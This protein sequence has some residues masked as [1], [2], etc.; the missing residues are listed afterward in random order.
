MCIKIEKT[1]VTETDMVV[2]SIFVKADG[3]MV[4]PFARLPLTVGKQVAEESKSDY[5]GENQVG[6]HRFESVE[7]AEY[8]TRVATNRGWD[9]NVKIYKSIIPAGTKVCSGEIKENNFG[10]GIPALL[11]PVIIQTD[12][13][14]E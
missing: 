6:F 9:W 11:T 1:F 7:A 14:V 13:M 4:S 10:E 2:Y 12:E 8:Y 5:V 3:I